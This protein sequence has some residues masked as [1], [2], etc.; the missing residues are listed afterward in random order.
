MI[1]S[2]LL[3]HENN[4]SASMRSNLQKVRDLVRVHYGPSG[5]YDGAVEYLER[6]SNNEFWTSATIP[7]LPFHESGLHDQ[8]GAR[9]HPDCMFHP[10]VLNALAPSTELRVIFRRER[11]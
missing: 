11:H 6:L 1:L 4:Y 9:G 10:S 2:L 5:G 3:R 8:E 7:R